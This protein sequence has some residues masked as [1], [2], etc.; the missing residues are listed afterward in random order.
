M[1]A[2]RNMPEYSSYKSERTGDQIDVLYHGIITVD[3]GLE[4]CIQSVR[5]WRPEFR[6]ILRGPGSAEILEKLKTVA[7]ENGVENRVVFAPPVPMLDLVRIAATADIGLSTPPKTSKHNIFALPNKLFEYIQAGLALCVCDLPDMASVVKQYDL[8]NLI[9]S[10]APE[11][12]AQAINRFD[13]ASID[14]FKANAREASKVLN[15]EHERS[16]L[17]ETYERALLASISG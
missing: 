17:V 7:C 2:I 8:G 1:I 6:L 12:I 5:F 3:R 13:R 16:V 14:R 11:S 15:W 4:E 9:D 10:V